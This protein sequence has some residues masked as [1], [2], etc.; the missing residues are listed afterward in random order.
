MAKNMGSELNISLEAWPADSKIKFRYFTLKL[1][2]RGKGMGVHCPVIKYLINKTL[3][4]C[5]QQKCHAAANTAANMLRT[6][7]K[8]N[9][10]FKNNFHIA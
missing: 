7:M 3:Q 10:F 1:L 9:L 5:R 8:T 2:S 4:T 6:M